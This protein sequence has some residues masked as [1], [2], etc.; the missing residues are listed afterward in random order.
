MASL[1]GMLKR[2]RIKHETYSEDGALVSGAKL[3]EQIVEELE[4][5]LH[6]RSSGELVTL[7][8]AARLS[9]F[10]ADYLRRLIRKGDLEDHGKPHKP[11]LALESLPRKPG[12]LLNRAEDAN[13]PEPKRRVAFSVIHPAA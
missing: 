11:L 9:G 3:A 4:A 6:S 12:C 1:H 7:S 8:E 5:L 13:V 10:S 2:W